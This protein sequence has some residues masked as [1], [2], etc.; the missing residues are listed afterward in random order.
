MGGA[1]GTVEINGKYIFELLLYNRGG[2][3]RFIE[4]GAIARIL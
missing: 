2:K 4:A 1:C 3:P